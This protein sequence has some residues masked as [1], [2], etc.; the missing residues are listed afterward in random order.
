VDG[1]GGAPAAAEFATVRTLSRWYPLI[2]QRGLAGRGPTAVHTSV[3]KHVAGATTARSRR[4]PTT[5]PHNRIRFRRRRGGAVVTDRH[6]SGE[7]E[8]M[9]GDEGVVTA[10]VGAVARTAGGEP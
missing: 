9:A 7:T 8:A 2:R 5:P 10:T 4:I 3:G 1:P 6:D